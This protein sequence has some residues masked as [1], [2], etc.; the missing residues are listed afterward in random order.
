GEPLRPADGRR[1]NAIACTTLNSHPVAV[2]ATH[3]IGSGSALWVWDLATGRQ[4]GEPLRPADGRRVNAIACTTLNSH[5]VA[6][7]ATHAYGSDAEDALLV[8]DLTTGRQIGKP[9]Q[10]S[11]APARTVVCTTLDNHPIALTSGDGEM[12]VWDLTTGRQI[13]D[14]LYTPDGAPVN[15]L[16]C[17]TFNGGAVA[18]TGTTAS[19]VHV[20]DIRARRPTQSFLAPGIEALEISPDGSLVLSLGLDVAVLQRQSGQH[21]DPW[22]RSR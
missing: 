14:P 10:A 3:A 17:A 20:W 19:T 1:V 13:G 4:I 7:T 22:W 12:C 5:P 6:V 8:W 15:A 11:G 9:L 18:V 2:T 16:A 21:A